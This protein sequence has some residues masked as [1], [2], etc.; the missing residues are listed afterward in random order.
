MNDTEVSVG[1]RRAVV[2]RDH[3]GV[4]PA[5]LEITAESEEHY[6][7]AS[8][9]LAPEVERGTAPWMVSRDAA[10]TLPESFGGGP[11]TGANAVWLEAVRDRR[12]YA[13]P[14]RGTEEEIS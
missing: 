6:R 12:G 2:L 13:D 1:G 9:Y 4:I 14:R 8:Q 10:H 11:W 7:R 3:G 5:D